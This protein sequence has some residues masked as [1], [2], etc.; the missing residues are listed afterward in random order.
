MSSYLSHDLHHLGRFET[1]IAERSQTVDFFF[2]AVELLRNPL[3]QPHFRLGIPIGLPPLLMFMHAIDTSAEV[4][5][6]QWT[7][8]F[9]SDPDIGHPTSSQPHRC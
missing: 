7:G 4:A 1:E 2:G 9:V 3:H 6:S 8:R 5:S